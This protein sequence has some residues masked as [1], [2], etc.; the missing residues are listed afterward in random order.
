MRKR[1]A[2]TGV[3][4]LS[5]ITLMYHRTPDGAPDDFFD[6]S[7]AEFQD[8]IRRLVDVGVPFVRFSD[9]DKTENLGDEVRVAVTFDDGHASNEKAF[10]FLADRGIVPA[11]MIVRNWSCD[12]KA[13]LSAAAISDLKTTCEFGGHGA[14]HIDLTSLSDSGLKQELASSREFLEDILGGW[15]DTMALP[16]GR[17]NARVLARAVEAGYRLVGNSV[18]LIQACKAVSIN[19]ICVNSQTLADDPVRW[20]SAGAAY[21]R[22]RR[23]RYVATR[24]GPRLLGDRLYAALTGWLKS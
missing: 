20:V 16:G 9:C 14:S 17:G 11:S 24:L 18:P 10:V 6:V 12:D 7:L 23:A 13:F 3:R 8:Q 1:I 2:C 19:R 4:E 15:V 22:M 5:V 21:W